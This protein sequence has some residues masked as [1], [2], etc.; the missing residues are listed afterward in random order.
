MKFHQHA[1]ISLALSGL[2]YA[3][4]KSWTLAA[5]NLIAGVCI[6]LD[7]AVDYVMQHGFPFRLKEFIHAY[8]E[9]TLLKVRLFHGW[10]WL[11]V[12]GLMVWLTDGNLWITGTLLGVGQHLVLDKINFGEHFLCYSL[13]WR[14]EKGFKS[15]AI[16]KRTRRGIK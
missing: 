13:L 7:Y 6:D 14:W 8:H 12:L 3:A 5:A 15:E 1:V 2:L 9:D 10:E 11:P 16:F 4:F